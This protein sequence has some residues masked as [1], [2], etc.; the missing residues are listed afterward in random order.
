MLIEALDT[1]IK[2]LGEHTYNDLKKSKKD[3]EPEIKMGLIIEHQPIE[4]GETICISK[5]KLK[6]SEHHIVATTTK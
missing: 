3:D 2:E 4:I 1:F 5:E 6:D